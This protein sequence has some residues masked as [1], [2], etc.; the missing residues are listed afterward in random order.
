MFHLEIFVFNFHSNLFLCCFVLFLLPSASGRAGIS[1]PIWI[2]GLLVRLSFSWDKWKIVEYP[3]QQHDSTHR[4]KQHT[5]K[6]LNSGPLKI[7]ASNKV[8]KD[9]S[10]GSPE[11]TNTQ[12]V[13]LKILRLLI[14]SRVWSKVFLTYYLLL[15]LHKKSLN[16]KLLVTKYG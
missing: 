13:P 4:S 15:S 2:K 8:P 11:T 9:T 14:K 5:D 16:R 6:L 3:S 12:T 1:L 7:W 10:Q